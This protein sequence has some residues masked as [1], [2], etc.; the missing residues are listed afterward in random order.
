MNVSQIRIISEIVNNL[1]LLVLELSSNY[2]QKLREAEI[3]QHVDETLIAC[4]I[5]AYDHGIFEAAR[6]PSNIKPEQQASRW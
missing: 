1:Q 6:T 4:C 3:F 5:I 2:L